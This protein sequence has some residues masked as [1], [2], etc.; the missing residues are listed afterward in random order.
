MCYNST[1]VR[2][3]LQKFEFVGVSLCFLAIVGCF[4]VVQFV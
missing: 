1:G 2:F 3:A 4:Y